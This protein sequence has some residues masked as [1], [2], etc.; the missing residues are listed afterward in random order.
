[1]SVFEASSRTTLVTATALAP[2]ASFRAS[3]TQRARI[4]EIQIYTVTAP[5]TVGG[6]GLMR[7]TALGTGTLTSAV[8][9][10]REPGD[11]ATTGQVVT[12]WATAAPTVGAVGTV[13]RRAAF[14]A[15]VGQ[16][17][18]WTWDIVDPLLVPLGNAA[19]GELVIVNL[20]ATAP[21]TFEISVTWEE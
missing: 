8:G 9:V 13:F 6:L 2:L 7:S 5:T 3:T 14:P 18:I 17:V 21:G 15:A 20:N 11:A 1:M 12:A 19:T 10:N 4:R 16:G